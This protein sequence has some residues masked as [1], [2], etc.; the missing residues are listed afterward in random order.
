[1]SE[2]DI[3]DLIN[4]PMKKLSFNRMSSIQGGGPCSGYT[5]TYCPLAFVVLFAGYKTG[6]LFAK[7]A[8]KAL[9][10]ALCTPCGVDVM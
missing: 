4:L 5:G 7:I 6:S 10:Q 8:G 1:M 3:P 2:F 9:K